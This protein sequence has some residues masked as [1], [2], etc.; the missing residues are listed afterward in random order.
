MVLMKLDL[1]ADPKTPLCPRWRPEGLKF[2]PVPQYQYSRPILG[3]LHTLGRL[4]IV[5]MSV[6]EIEPAVQ[7]SLPCR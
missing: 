5:P 4:I 1:G 6:D 3:S 7:S 2:I